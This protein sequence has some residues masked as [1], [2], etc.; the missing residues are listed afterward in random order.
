MRVSVMSVSLYPFYSDIS[1]NSLF[2]KYVT[3]NSHLVLLIKN[4]IDAIVNGLQFF[5][6]VL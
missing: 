4:Q 1:M 5:N 6:T 2:D 3:S